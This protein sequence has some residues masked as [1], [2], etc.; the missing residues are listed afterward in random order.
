[1]GNLRRNFDRFCFQNRSKG[2]PNLM[3]YI[4]LGNAVCLLLGLF[5]GGEDLFYWLCFDK[6]Q[7]LQGQVWRL[8]TYVFTIYTEPMLGLI[9]LYFFYSI[10]RSV[11]QHMGTFKFNLYYFSGLLLMDLFAMIF[12]PVIPEA[13]TSQD[14]AQYLQTT[15]YMYYNMSYYLHLCML[16]TFATIYPDSQFM[17]LFVIP[18]KGKLLGLLYLIL[19]AADIFNM[20]VPVFYFPHNLFPLVA[21]G[22][23]LLFFGSQV[24]NLLPGT[25]QIARNKK[26][27]ARQAAEPISFHPVPRPAPKKEDFNH[28][29]TVCGRTDVTNP[30]LEFR[31]CSRC[32]G[33][34]CYCQEH[35][36]DHTHI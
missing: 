33:Y 14:Q 2:I 36:N 26:A 34:H 15:V 27:A 29:C 5:N 19:V 9:L 3:L 35:I 31:Y 25:V 16:I 4:V 6:T 22:N 11:E 13:I 12:C 20:S 7:I 17:I 23:Y 10:G 21:L 24:R 32:S 1:M 18:V 8:F 30:E 28:K